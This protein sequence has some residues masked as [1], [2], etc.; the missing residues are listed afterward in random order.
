M[1]PI[2]GKECHM[3]GERRGCSGITREA[4]TWGNH[5]AASRC[6]PS[7]GPELDIGTAQ[8]AWSNGEGLGMRV[9]HFATPPPRHPPISLLCLRNRPVTPGVIR[10]V[11]RTVPEE[12]RTMNPR[13]VVALVALLP[14]AAFAAPDPADRASETPSASPWATDTAC[15]VTQPNGAVR[16][17]FGRTEPPQ[18]GDPEFDGGYGNATLWTNLWMWGEGEVAVPASH[19]RP[20]GYFGEM[21]WSWYR[22]IPGRLTIE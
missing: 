10:V 1:D 5:V 12:E 8:R 18:A 20:D 6:R 16:P 22:Y 19:I 9:R 4:A 17:K 14:I 13:T 11:L 3:E 7:D 21:K 15:P 2:P